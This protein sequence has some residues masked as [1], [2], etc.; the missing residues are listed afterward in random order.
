MSWGKPPAKKSFPPKCDVGKKTVKSGIP[1]RGEKPKI[2][3]KNPDYWMTYNASE[4]ENNSF[5]KMRR[6]FAELKCQKEKMEVA[7]TRNHL[8]YEDSERYNDDMND[9]CAGDRM[10]M[11]VLEKNIREL[12]EKRLAVGVEKMKLR[13]KMAYSQ[14]AYIKETRLNRDLEEIKRKL[15]KKN[16]TWIKLLS[17]FKPKKKNLE[18]NREHQFS[19]FFSK[20]ASKKITMCEDDLMPTC[21]PSLSAAQA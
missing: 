19:G 15:E 1:P 14:I 20:W 12:E 11:K 10:D 21:T 5:Y 16:T 8:V 18:K 7:I 2:K 4:F 6:I 17:I 13:D 3:M 9:L